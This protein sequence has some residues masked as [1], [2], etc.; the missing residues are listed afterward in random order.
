[1]PTLKLC[2]LTLT[3]IKAQCWD[4]IEGWHFQLIRHLKFIHK[5]KP[6]ILKLAPHRLE[7]I[8]TQSTL[9]LHQINLKILLPT[10]EAM[11]PPKPG[12]SVGQTTPSSYTPR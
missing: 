5:I 4:T 12:R 7:E 6:K 8:P 11:L 3:G 2:T 9:S 10:D 1:M